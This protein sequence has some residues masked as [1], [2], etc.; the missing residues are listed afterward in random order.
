M[1]MYLL[2]EKLILTKLPPSIDENN[3][4]VPALYLKDTFLSYAF[5]HFTRKKDIRNFLNKILRDTILKIDKYKMILSV[6]MAVVNKFLKFNNN[7]YYY[8]NKNATTKKEIIQK[9][10]KHYQPIINKNI[11][12]KN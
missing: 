10:K 9:K 6:D 4:N 8:L 11:F 2:L 7:K 5:K 3:K 1:M 12:S